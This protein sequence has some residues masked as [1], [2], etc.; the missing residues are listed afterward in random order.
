MDDSS[1]A[2]AEA[3]SGSAGSQA[4]GVCCIYAKNPNGSCYESDGEL[5]TCNTGQ[6]EASCAEAVYHNNCCTDGAG[7][8]VPCDTIFVPGGEDCG[9]CPDTYE[10]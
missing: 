5:L 9:D 8:P 10:E 3:S 6:T 1:S 2:S 7:N 4:I